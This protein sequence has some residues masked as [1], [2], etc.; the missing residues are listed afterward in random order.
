MQLDNYIFVVRPDTFCAYENGFNFI[1][2]FNYEQFNQAGK[3]IKESALVNELTKQVTPLNMRVIIKIKN[4]FIMHTLNA[5]KSELGYTIAIDRACMSSNM[6][7]VSIIKYFADT[8]KIKTIK[9]IGI[10]KDLSLTSTISLVLL[11]E[12]DIKETHLINAKSLNTKEI[13]NN[14]LKFEP[15]SRY[16][17]EYIDRI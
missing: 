8:F 9:G 5:K 6:I 14:L 7:S 4:H 12:A 11:C 17:L 1:K 13:K 10:L 2:N 3:F 16:L 15:L